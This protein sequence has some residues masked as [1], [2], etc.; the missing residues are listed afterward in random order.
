MDNSIEISNNR[1]LR[2]FYGKK[3]L[4]DFIIFVV[5][6][7]HGVVV[8]TAVSEYRGCELK[9]QFYSLF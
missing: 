1:D 8:R 9:S 7:P 2:F 6:L 5:S 4:V 3:K